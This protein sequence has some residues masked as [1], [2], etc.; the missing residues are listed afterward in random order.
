MDKAKLSAIRAKAGRGT[1]LPEHLRAPLVALV[2]AKGEKG[3]CEQ[4]GI[5]RTA[6]TRALAGF[7][8]QKGTISLIK[9]ALSGA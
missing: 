8:L 5:S 2:E 3:A 7:G 9:V 4:V 1:P 6:L